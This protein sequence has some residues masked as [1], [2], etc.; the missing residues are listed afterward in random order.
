MVMLGNQLGGRT[1]TWTLC[2]MVAFAAGMGCMSL[3]ALAEPVEPQSAPLSTVL[4]AIAAQPWAPLTPAVARLSVQQYGAQLTAYRLAPAAV[5]AKII[6]QLIPT[7][8]SAAEMAADTKSMLIIN[9]GF[10]FIKDDGS[11]APTGLLLA[12]GKQLAPQTRCKICTGVLYTDNKGLG[13][14]RPKAMAKKRGVTNALQ[15]GPMLVEQRATLKFRTD[16]PA[17]ERSV[18]CLSGDGIIVLALMT[19]LSLHDTAALMQASVNEGGFGC[20]QAINLD[21]GSSTQLVSAV[22][23]AV[24]QIGYPRAVQNVI[25]FDLK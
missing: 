9:G 3:A 11:L 4:Q 21:G 1:M 5:R 12:D 16:G 22:A 20:R 10:F 8:N 25:A 2:R 18:V 23:G 24:E 6:P 14:A 7:G 13:I 19:P 17:A 15:V